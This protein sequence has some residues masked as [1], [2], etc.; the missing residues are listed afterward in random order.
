MSPGPWALSIRNSSAAEWIRRSCLAPRALLG[1]SLGP[2]RSD[3]FLASK[4]GLRTV[5][6]RRETNRRPDAL[7]SACNEALRRLKT[8]YIDL[9]YLHSIGQDCPHR[10]ERL[11]LGRPS[12]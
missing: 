2:R 3:F 12:T 4:C 10:R 8:D 9:Y 7:K 5:R 11:D 1:E 6:G